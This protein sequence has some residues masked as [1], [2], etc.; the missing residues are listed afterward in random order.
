MLLPGIRGQKTRIG[1]SIDDACTFIFSQDGVRLYN[2]IK[3]V[4]NTTFNIKVD[5]FSTDAESASG[6]EAGDDDDD[7]DDEGDHA[8]KLAT[9]PTLPVMT[10]VNLQEEMTTERV[11]K[12]NREQLV[13]VYRQFAPNLPVEGISDAKLK[14]AIIKHYNL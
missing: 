8:I 6:A 9:A 7:D 3:S 4:I 10:A 13:F 1:A 14:A 2:A 5:I 12:F 11:K